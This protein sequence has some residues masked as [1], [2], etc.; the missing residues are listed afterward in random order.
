MARGTEDR[1][2]GRPEV[3]VELG[4]VEACLLPARLGA[5]LRRVR[6]RLAAEQELPGEVVEC[7]ARL[8]LGDAGEHVVDRGLAHD[9]LADELRA[10]AIGPLW[11]EMF[12][13]V[14]ERVGELA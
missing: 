2:G 9:D 13:V 3:A 10:R 12:E 1:G 6:H 4:Q 14:P 11:P 7:P 5:A 8:V